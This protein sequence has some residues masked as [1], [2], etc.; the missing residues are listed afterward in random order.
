MKK[1]IIKICKKI[2][3]NS[4]YILALSLLSSLVVG[5]LAYIIPS[6]TASFIET[7][8][9]ILVLLILTATIVFLCHKHDKKT[10]VQHNLSIFGLSYLWMGYFLYLVFNMEAIKFA[11]SSSIFDIGTGVYVCVG[12]IRAVIALFLWVKHDRKKIKRQRPNKH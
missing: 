2:W 12:L 5:F 9:G 3:N 1:F 8:S 11:S 10:L 6:H 7:L 4:V